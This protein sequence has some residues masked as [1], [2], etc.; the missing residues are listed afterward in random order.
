MNRANG[1]W[2][3]RKGRTQKAIDAET[4][5]SPADIRQSEYANSNLLRELN[6]IVAVFTD[7][8]KEIAAS[9]G[10]AVFAKPIHAVQFDRQ[11]NNWLMS[12]VDTMTRSIGANP[13][14]RL[15]IYQEDVGKVYGVPSTGKEVFDAS[16]DKS[17]GMRTTV[18]NLLGMDDTV[19][20]PS[21]AAERTL[22]QLAGRDL[23]VQEAAQFKV[24]FVVYVVSIIVDS[25]TPDSEESVNFWP[26]F[27]S[28]ENIHNLNWASYILESVISA[29]CSAKM[30]SRRKISPAPPAGT[31]LFLEVAICLSSLYRPSTIFLFYNK[32]SLI[33][34]FCVSV[35]VCAFGRFST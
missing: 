34:L 19:T 11:F 20:S 14:R 7:E 24:S 2:I 22:R 13:G 21:A 23:S 32:H 31:A 33:S 16:L 35:F 17:Q 5:R 3:G 10:F 25:K 1:S 4:A 30:A 28:I 29:C 26:A 6:S 8:Q 9:T 12:K 18:E 15:T 27:T